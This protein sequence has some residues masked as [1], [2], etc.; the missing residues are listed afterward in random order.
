MCK[1]STTTWL[2]RNK[3]PALVNVLNILLYSLLTMPVFEESQA[4]NKIKIWQATFE[5]LFSIYTKD[6]HLVN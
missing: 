4:A 2:N 6:Y 3:L 1:K 5:K